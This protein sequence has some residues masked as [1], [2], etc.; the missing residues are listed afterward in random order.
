MVGGFLTTIVEAL[1]AIPVG[2]VFFTIPQR[3]LS[4]LLLVETLV[5]VAFPLDFFG[6]G[7]GSDT[8]RNVP[9]HCSR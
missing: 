3:G 7:S 1:D 9:P 4:I 5:A 6:G 8:F 2:V